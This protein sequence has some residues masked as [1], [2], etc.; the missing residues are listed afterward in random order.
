MS[1]SSRSS[2]TG[3][4]VNL[5]APAPNL[6]GR[7]QRGRPV[8]TDVDLEVAPGESEAAVQ[9]AL[10]RLMHGRTTIIVAHRLSTVREA[11]RIVVLDGACVVEQGRHDELMARRGTYHRLVE[12]QLIA[13]QRAA[14]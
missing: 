5:L 12:R 1:R 6:H 8:L 3:A 10:A 7:R 4:V 14:S 11:D 9:A 2:P 13:D